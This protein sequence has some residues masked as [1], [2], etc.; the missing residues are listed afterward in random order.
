MDGRNGAGREV[1][2]AEGR[3]EEKSEKKSWTMLITIYVSAVL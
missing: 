3:G 1:E 2:E